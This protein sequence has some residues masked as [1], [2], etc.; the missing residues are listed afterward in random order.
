MP[1]VQSVLERRWD[2]L[3]EDHQKEASEIVLDF[4]AEEMQCPACLT[5]FETGPKACPDCGL[6]L[7]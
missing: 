3:L 2:G 4:A 6:F 7:G 5:T 1:Q